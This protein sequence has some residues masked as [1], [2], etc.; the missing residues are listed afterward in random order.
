SSKVL[1]HEVREFVKWLSGDHGARGCSMGRYVKMF[2]IPPD[3]PSMD[4][5][6]AIAF[7]WSLG[8]QSIQNM[9]P[10]DGT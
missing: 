7:L 8:E 5:N 9:F 6:Q 10:N 1:K 3:P 2:C 4:I